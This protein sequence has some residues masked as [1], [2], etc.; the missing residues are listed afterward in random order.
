MDRIFAL[1][2]NKLSVPRCQPQ[3]VGCV[4][5]TVSGGCAFVTE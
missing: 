3:T 1:I 4:D 2:F 5:G